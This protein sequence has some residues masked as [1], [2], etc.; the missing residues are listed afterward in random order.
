VLSVWSSPVGMA[1]HGMG[2]E[3]RE[4]EQ[5]QQRLATAS[6]AEGSELA[7]RAGLDASPLTA[8][9]SSDGTCRAIL[10]A[11]DEQDARLIVTG[12]RGLGGIESLLL[13]SV[14][15]CVVHHARGAVLVVHTGAPP[16]G[17][18]ARH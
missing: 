5:Q 14:S 16:P 8:C 15:E 7:R 10:D 12:A 13:G 6:A 17:T 11:A 2:P 1:V 18:D 3:A 4:H 9:G